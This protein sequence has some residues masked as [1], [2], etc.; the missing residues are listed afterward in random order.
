MEDAITAGEV[1]IVIGMGFGSALL[2]A[3]AGFGGSLFISERSTRERRKGVIRAIMG[4]LLT[5]SVHTVMAAY[6]IDQS[7]QFSSAVWDDGKFEIAQAVTPQTFGR[8]LGIYSGMWVA[9]YA[10]EHL[11]E[12]DE[13]QMKTLETFYESVRLAF[14]DMLSGARQGEVDSWKEIQA[15]GPELAELERRM[16]PRHAKGSAGTRP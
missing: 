9:R 14:N 4:E 16:G 6:P 12:G 8:L 7:S 15:F 1:W 11:A 3:L 5:N 2:G 13:S 10:A